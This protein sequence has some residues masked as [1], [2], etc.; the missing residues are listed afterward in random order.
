VFGSK[1]V[2]RMCETKR[3]QRNGEEK[4]HEEKFEFVF[5]A[6]YF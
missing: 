3:E 2:A 4:L 5:I 6:W 1:V